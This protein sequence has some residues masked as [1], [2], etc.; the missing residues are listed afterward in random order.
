MKT[1][2]AAILLAGSILACKGPENKT[3]TVISYFGDSISWEADA[4]DAHQLISWMVGK[5][6]AEARVKG[7]VLEVCQAKG[8]WMDLDLGHGEFMTV[9]FKDYGFFM[10]KDCAGNTVVI[11]GMVKKEVEDVDWLRHKA[12]DAGKS[13]EEIEAI[14]EPEISYTFLAR[15]VAMVEPENP[16]NKPTH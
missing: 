4:V 9:R 8:C 7:Q 13:P 2:I 6:S 16:T 3:Q 14:T 12:Q 1:Q 5:D 15:G 11:E 10:P